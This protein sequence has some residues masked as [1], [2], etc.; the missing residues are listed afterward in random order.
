MNLHRLF[1]I[2][3][4]K[5]GERGIVLLRLVFPHAIHVPWV[6]RTL[7]TL[8]QSQ[9]IG[10]KQVTLSVH[11]RDG[12]AICCRAHKRSTAGDGLKI[13]LPSE[14]SKDSFAVRGDCTALYG[15]LFTSGSKKKPG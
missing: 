10:R 6:P 8:Y 5:D 1:L 11:C 13:A 15:D 14:L 7:G 12:G 3:L 4:G 2:N 9:D